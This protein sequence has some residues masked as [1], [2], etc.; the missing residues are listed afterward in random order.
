MSIHHHIATLGPSGKS[1]IAPGTV[2]SLVAIILAF[3]IM[4][5]P[6]GWA[7]LWAL[8][9]VSIWLGTKSANRYMADKSTD[10]D[11][12]EIVIDELAGMWLTIV[13]WHVWVVVMTDAWAGARETIELRGWDIQFLAIGF[14]L[15]RF[16]DIVK[17]WPIGW[18]DRKVKGGWGV[19]LDDLIAGIASGTVLYALYLFWPLITG[20]MPESSV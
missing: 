2:G 1:K 10:H 13:V 3:N 7:V 11:P 18:A 19:M 12:K 6:M 4:H 8:T 15:F 5:L 20:E 9:A 16:F 14:V 17:P